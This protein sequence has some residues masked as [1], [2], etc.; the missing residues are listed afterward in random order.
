MIINGMVV[1]KI[2]KLILSFDIFVVCIMINLEFVVSIFKLIKVLSKVVIGKNILILWGIFKII[3][4]SVCN[5][6]NLFLFMCFKLLINLIMFDKLIK[7]ISIKEV[8]I[9]IVWLIYKFKILNMI[10]II[11]FCLSL[12]LKCFIGILFSV[13]IKIVVISN[14]VLIGYILIMLESE[15]FLI[16]DF[17]V[18][19]VRK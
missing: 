14:V 5:R 3:K 12:F 18:L 15:L 8:V 9:M 19:S 13:F 11:F 2:E 4:N 10:Y 7:I 16:V 1:F 17:V 6:L